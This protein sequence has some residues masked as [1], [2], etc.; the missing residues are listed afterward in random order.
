MELKVGDKIPNFS[1]IK[2]MDSTFDSKSVVGEK[3]CY[4]FL[5]KTILSMYRSSVQFRDQYED[6]KD[7]VQKLLES[8]VIV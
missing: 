8:V 5:S 7:L 1:A 3:R 2:V 4:L 6:F